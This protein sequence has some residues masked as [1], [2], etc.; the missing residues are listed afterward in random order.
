[1]QPRDVRSSENNF[2]QSYHPTGDPSATKQGVISMFLGSATVLKYEP[3][4]ST[5]QEGETS[6]PYDTRGFDPA[7]ARYGALR[8]RNPNWS[9]CHV[10]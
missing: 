5:V 3:G 10:R 2:R 6:G 1:M 7:D 4:G 8:V 9:R